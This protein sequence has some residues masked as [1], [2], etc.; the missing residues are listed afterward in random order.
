[1]S[2]RELNEILQ[3]FRDAQG[4][5]A[6]VFD[7]EACGQTPTPDWFCPSHWGDA[8]Q[9]VGQ[10]GR[11]AA[12]FIDGEHGQMVLRHYLRGG[13]VA[14]L[15]RDTFVWQGRDSVRS[16]AEFR[17]LQRLLSLGLPVPRPVAAFY[18]RHGLG[19]RAAILLQRLAGVETLAHLIAREGD[20]APWQETGRLI[21]RFH[22]VGLNH[23]DLN[24]C[25]LLFDD[26]GKA[27]MIDFD[28]SRLQTP[29]AAWQAANLA[30][31]R[32]SLVKVAGEDIAAPGF[33]RLQAAYDAAMRAA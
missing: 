27:W 14:K 2:R 19:Y 32:R 22:R 13:L 3:P 6:I 15:S 21:A 23:A 9:P 28:K 30:R 11:G 4:E 8:A 26:E 29:K 12:W 10:G 18:R 16:F 1:M 25:N 24:A 20:A 33:A 7:T 17:L 5:G 31:L